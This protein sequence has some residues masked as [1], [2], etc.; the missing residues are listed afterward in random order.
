MKLK[1]EGDE[2]ASDMVNQLWTSFSILFSI[3]EDDTT[4]LCLF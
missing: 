1:C 4:K 3:M 2:R